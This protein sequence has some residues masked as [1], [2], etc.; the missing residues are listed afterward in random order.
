MWGGKN[1]RRT[2]HALFGFASP[3]HLPGE[4]TSLARRDTISVINDLSRLVRNDPEAIDIY[5]ALG[6][7]FRAQGDIERAV[8][9]REQLIARPGL[10]AKFKSRSYFELGQDYLR[11]G[12]IDRSLDAFRQAAEQGHEADAVTRELATLFAQAGDFSKA[13]EEY[14]QLGHYLAQAHYLVRLAEETQSDKAEKLL[15]KA[16][17][18]YPGSI[19][20]W[21]AVV[22]RAAG[23]EAWKKLPSLLE[24]ALAKI[25]ATQRFLVFE[26]LLQT[27]ARYRSRH[28]KTE[29]GYSP[30]GVPYP[31]PANL[32]DRTFAKALCGAVI[33][34]LEN[35]E[36]H[37]LLHYYGAL[38]L[39]QAQEFEAM[40]I[41]LAKALVVQPDFWAARLLSLSLAAKKHDLSPVVSLQI[42]YFAEELKHLKR[43][44]CTVC[45]FRGNTVFYRCHRCSSWHS[46]AFRSSLQE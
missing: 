3:L 11:A 13:S 25:T 18:I 2:L 38:L 20:A 8:M 32:D 36:P 29:D 7:L 34:V 21:S 1:I 33:P 17:R 28:K 41:W 39:E 24:K 40:E 16:L 12:V 4:G 14:G 44:I 37:L 35:Q 9:I 15:K 27:E 31:S 26:A 6:N 19:E 22:S 42:D 43:F 30:L 46:L 45:G 23:D 5:L 10:N